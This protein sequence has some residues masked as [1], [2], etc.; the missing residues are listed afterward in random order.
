MACICFQDFTKR[1]ISVVFLAGTLIFELVKA[2][3]THNY[4]YNNLLIN[5]IVIITQLSSTFIYIKLTRGKSTVV[6]DQFIGWGDIILLA[7]LAPGFSSS[8]FILFILISSLTTLFIY[9]AIRLFLKKSIVQ[10]PLAGIMAFLYFC[11]F[12]AD[13]FFPDHFNQLSL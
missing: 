11:M 8:G 5:F 10:L 1:E 2:F 13:F 6:M 9:A 3:N 7:A 4:S 12:S